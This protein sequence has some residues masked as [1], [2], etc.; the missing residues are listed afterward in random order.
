MTRI[1]VFAKQPVPGRVK[2]RLIPALGAEGAA[3]LAAEMLATTVD[4]ALATGL[5]VELCGEPDPSR[6]Y[7]G[8]PVSLSAQGPGDL[9]RRLA[10]A[11]ER[12]LA[13]GPALLIGTDCPALDAG[14]LRAAAA[15]LDTHDAFIHPTKDGGYALLALR[16]FHP[17]LFEGIPW[18]TIS[19]AADTRARI[20]ALGWPVQVGDTLADVDEPKDLRLIAR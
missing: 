20:E 11:A 3:G 18:S 1:V 5:P 8:A 15:A 19:V 2:T 17:S 16:R 13:S 9:G 6:W 14:R 7:R 10:R 12:T 4:A